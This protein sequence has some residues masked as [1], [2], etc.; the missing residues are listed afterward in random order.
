[1]EDRKTCKVQTDRNRKKIQKPLVFT[2]V[3][4]PVCLTYKPATSDGGLFNVPDYQTG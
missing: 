1:M 2:L 4:F 3:F